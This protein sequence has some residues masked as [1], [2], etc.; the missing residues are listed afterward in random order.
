MCFGK[1]KA[2]APAP[3]VQQ[4][5]DNAAAVADNQAQVDRQ[6]DE[7]RKNN[8]ALIEAS[9]RQSAAALAESQRQAN[10]QIGIQQQAFAMQTAALAAQQKAAKDAADAIFN[11]S[12]KAKN[13]NIAQIMRDNLKANSTGVTSTMLTGTSGVDSSSLTLG[14]NKLLGA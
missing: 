3:I 13:P 2:A 5:Q 14:K 11:V 9:D 4:T 6:I 1:K 10:E 7:Q 8:Q 12:Q